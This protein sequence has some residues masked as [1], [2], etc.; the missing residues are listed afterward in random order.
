MSG[1]LRVVSVTPPLMLD[2]ES[3]VK[4]ETSSGVQSRQSL[5]VK[6]CLS[7]SMGI[8]VEEDELLGG[9]PMFIRCK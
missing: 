7:E 8:L 4:A 1:S 9:W 6:A 2:R 3:V 5:F